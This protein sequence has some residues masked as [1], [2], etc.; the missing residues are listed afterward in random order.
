MRRFFAVVLIL[1]LAAPVASAQGVLSD[2]LAGKLVKPEPGVFAWYD[3]VDAATG[4]AFAMRLA[5]VGE[6][7][8]NR[9]TGYWLETE[10]IPQVGFPVVYKMLLTGPANDPK[11]VHRIL[12]REGQG[13]VQDVPVEPEVEG[14]EKP[15]DGKRELVG[16]ETMVTP[17]GELEVEHHTLGE[18]EQRTD[19]WTNDLVRPL[20]LVRMASAHGEL[21]LRRY[22]KGG[23]DGVSII[24]DGAPVSQE[25][26]RPPVPEVRV[27]TRVQT[28]YDGKGQEP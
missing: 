12:V 1:V 17:Q 19:V 9:K 21:H 22:G 25:E 13:V 18:G 20:G 6:E 15:A 24:P 26:A 4:R 28:N 10:V 5:V 8:V 14:Q 27:E 16:K 3:L 7:K 23:E 11:H 2:V